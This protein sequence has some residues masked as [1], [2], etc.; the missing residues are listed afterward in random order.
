MYPLSTLLSR[1]SEGNH[2]KKEVWV[3][4]QVSKFF[5]KQTKQ[6]SKPGQHRW[7]RSAI[8]PSAKTECTRSGSRNTVIHLYIH[9]HVC[10]QSNQTGWC[11]RMEYKG[12]DNGE[13]LRM[14]SVTGVWNEGKM[15][16]GGREMA[17]SGDE[18]EERRPGL[19]TIVELHF[20]IF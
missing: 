10:R 9:T 6:Y 5:N 18:R 4:M 2:R 7:Q 15:S 3:Q 8:V 1:V 20:T 14:C 12:S 17:T 19:L 11:V 13:Q 16:P